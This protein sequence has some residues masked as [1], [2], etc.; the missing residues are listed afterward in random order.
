MILMTMI[1]S[2]YPFNFKIISSFSRLVLLFYFIFMFLIFKTNLK[3]K[4]Q[5]FR[6]AVKTS[7]PNYVLY[8]LTCQLAWRAYVL[9]CLRTYMLTY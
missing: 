1:L 6:G 3:L 4:P 7:L 8:V 2:G 9:A 5:L